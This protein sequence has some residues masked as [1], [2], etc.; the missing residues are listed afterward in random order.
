MSEHHPT[1]GGDAS[2][3]PSPGPAPT[4]PHDDWRRPLRPGAPPRPRVPFA[5]FALLGCVLVGGC[6][7]FGLL[8]LVG[9]PTG[10]V[11]LGGG[12]TLLEETIVEGT[13]DAKVVLIEVEGPIAAVQGGG[14][15]GGGVDLVER[16]RKELEAAAKDERVRAL[17][18]SIDSPG[19]T[20]TASD[21]VWHLVS[22]FKRKSNKP[23]VVHM[24]ALCASGGYYIAVAGDE[25]ICEPTTITG[26]IGV[27]LQGVNFHELLEKHG[28]KPQTITSGPNKALLDPLS[29]PSPEHLEIIQRMV[30]ETYGTFVKR[31]VEG[32]RLDEA[33]VRKLADGRIYTAQQALD[34]KLVDAIGYREDA[35][36]RAATRGGTTSPTLVRY[37]RP[38]TFAD[39]LAGA[40]RA[41]GEP[42]ALERLVPAA[43]DELTTP[44]L[45]ALWRGSR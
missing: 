4:G 27:I 17:L 42:V 28:V 19:G 8:S 18:L 34:A 10:A 24:G 44:R 20:V 38:P 16:V 43:L 22:E 23:V 35:L 13:G 41:P 9:G 40:A 33:T 36:A 37:T 12:R 21:Q 6:L 15:F 29:P 25:L 1:S 14:L 5:V 32:R 7:L 39:L 3:P 26:S 45:L 11:A 31:V 2:P 30:D